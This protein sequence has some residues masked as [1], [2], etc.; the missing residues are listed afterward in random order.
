MRSQEEEVM[1]IELLKAMSLDA[2]TFMDVAVDFSQDEWEWLTLAQR[3]LYKKVMLEN[4][5]NLA[6]LGLCISKP[7]VISFLEQDKEPWMMKGELTR[8]LCPG[9][10]YVWMKK[11][12]SLNQDIYEEKLSQAMIMERLTSYDL[13]CSTL[14]E[15]WKCED[16]FERELTTLSA[17]FPKSSQM[18]PEAAIAQKL[19]EF[20]GTF[21]TVLT[22]L[23]VTYRCSHLPLL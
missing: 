4:Y 18:P 10:E 5:S 17:T 19:G 13:E 12:L 7:D 23:W 3:T 14:G 15:N 2:V 9:L 1:G 22:R 21:M 8:G 20:C 11:E 6:S 16:L